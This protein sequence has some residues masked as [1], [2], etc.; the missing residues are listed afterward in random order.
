MACPDD[1]LAQE[2]FSLLSSQREES[3]S[4][5]MRRANSWEK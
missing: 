1:G 2:A 5:E 4:Q 3:V